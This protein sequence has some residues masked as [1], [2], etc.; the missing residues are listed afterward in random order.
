MKKNNN[1]NNLPVIANFGGFIE[2]NWH[3]DYAEI[4]RKKKRKHD[5][6]SAIKNSGKN[7]KKANDGVFKGTEFAKELAIN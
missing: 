4:V 3:G 6:V 7:I 2:R 1:K 5:V